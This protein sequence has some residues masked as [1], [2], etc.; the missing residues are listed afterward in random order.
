VED[1]LDRYPLLPHEVVAEFIALSVVESEYTPGLE[2]S[3]NIDGHRAEIFDNGRGMQLRPDN[4]DHL[5]HAERA[6]TSIYPISA[7]SPGTQILLTRLVW[8]QRGSL[9]PA[10]ANHHCVSLQYWSRREGTEWT[11]R[12]E[13][14]KCLGPP[15]HVGV[16]SETG[17]AIVM[18]TH[19]QIDGLALARLV[20]EIA[21]TPL[22]I[23]IEYSWSGKPSGETAS[24]GTS[25]SETASTNHP[26][27]DSTESR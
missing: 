20:A 24:S 15:E 27:H 7:K 11:Q 16:T 26:K 9:G 6:L 22:S 8:G 1:A 2:V 18:L 25:P 19:G 4:G 23:K 21:A 13:H 17:T 3:V 14:G 12:F 5:S 10:L